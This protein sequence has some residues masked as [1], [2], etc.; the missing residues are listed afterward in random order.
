MPAR[1]GGIDRVMFAVEVGF[2]VEVGISRDEPADLCIVVARSNVAQSRVSLGSITAGCAVH[3]RAAA[4]ARAPD[5]VAEA[6]EIDRSGDRLAGVGDCSLVSPA[7]EERIFAVL[8][9]QA[10]AVGIHRRCGASLLFGQDLTACVA[11]LGRRAAVGAR[12]T[13]SGTVI[14]ETALGRASDRC[15]E[16]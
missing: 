10:V 2:L 16:E 13:P 1:V 11:E 9:D 8:A 15:A 5:S 14:R 6:V 4:A 7:I 3:V 12:N